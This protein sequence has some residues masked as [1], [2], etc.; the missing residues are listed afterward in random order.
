MAALQFPQHQ[1]DMPRRS[2]ATAALVSL[3]LGLPV[4]A[5]VG[6]TLLAGP[7]DQEMLIEADKL[8]YGWET[9]GLQLDRHVLPR[10]GDAIL[11]AASAPLD[12]APGLPPLHGG[13]RGVQR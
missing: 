1:A 4:F 9:Q 3:A 6:A 12:R 7:P 2:A 10:R 8:V 5:Q 11:R 13:A